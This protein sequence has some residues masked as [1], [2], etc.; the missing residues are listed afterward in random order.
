M[1]NCAL[2][3]LSAGVSPPAAGAGTGAT[4]VAVSAAAGVSGTRLAAVAPDSAPSSAPD[5]A[6]ASAAAVCSGSGRA[7]ASSAKTTPRSRSMLSTSMPWPAYCGRRRVWPSMFAS[8]GEE[9]TPTSTKRSTPR[10]GVPAP[11]MAPGSLSRRSWVSIHRTGEA[12]CQAKSSM[13][14]VRPI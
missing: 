8:V 4:R 11:P 2:S 5:S 7:T 10:P 9:P 14:R 13:S 12:N 6:A 1:A 3:G